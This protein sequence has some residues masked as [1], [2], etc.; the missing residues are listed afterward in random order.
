VALITATLLFFQK[1]QELEINSDEA[2]NLQIIYPEGLSLVIPEH[3]NPIINQSALMGLK[4]K[5]SSSFNNEASFSIEFVELRE[6]TIEEYASEKYPLYE[7]GEDADGNVILSG[8][9]SDLAFN[10]SKEGDFRG[11]IIEYDNGVFVAECIV[12]GPFNA[13]LINSCGEIIQSLS[14]EQ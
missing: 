12:E 1:P 8:P 11:K 13:R 9:L 3:W 5:Y 2:G 7:P 4:T 10:S 6:Q 14:L